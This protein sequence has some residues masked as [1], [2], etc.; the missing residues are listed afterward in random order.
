[1]KLVVQKDALKHALNTLSP[2]TKKKE[3]M[4][5]SCLLFEV[6]DDKLTLRASDRLVY[7]CLELGEDDGIILA[8]GTAKFTVEEARFSQWVSNVL[9]DEVTFVQDGQSVQVSCGSFS[10]PFPSQ[11][12]DLFTA[13]AVFEKQY[14]E[15]EEVLISDVTA[16]LEAIGF[17]KRF[18]ATKDDHND[19]KGEF[20]TTELHD[21]VFYSTNAQLIGF[22]KDPALQGIL[23]IGQEQLG[24]VESFLKR[25]SDVAPVSVLKGESLSF[26]KVSEDIWFGFV[27]PK[28]EL[29]MAQISQLPTGLDEKEQWEVNQ[30]TL[31]AAVG[32]L[33]AT[34]EE[35]ETKITATL[36][37][38]GE[39]ALLTLQMR[40]V[41]RNKP[42]QVELS[43]H[44]IAE[45]VSEVTFAFDY[46]NLKQILNAFD[47]TI[48]LSHT[49]NCGYLKFHQIQPTGA[50]KVVIMSLAR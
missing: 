12:P 34:A 6:N 27:Q 50:T 37:G 49:E 16:M 11:D 31:K 38:Q 35:G 7:T 24:Q 20:Q 47:E 30:K 42:A 14:S 48:T 25:Q 46:N 22:F 29:P 9:E 1:M 15:A 17:A 36:Q 21:G 10:S 39:N 32:A 33:L 40:S 43:V 19:P 23:R 4:I 3:G 26:L 28:T 45:D 44:R 41:K 18:V 5:T 2:S 8:E 13:N